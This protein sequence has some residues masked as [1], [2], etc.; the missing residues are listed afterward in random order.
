[1][2]GRVIRARSVD[3]TALH[4]E[5]DGPD[6]APPILFLH[7]VAGTMRS[8][9]LQVVELASRYR[10]IRFNARGYPPSDVPENPDLYSQM[11]AVEDAEAVLDELSIESAHIVGFSMGGFAAA[12]L[13]LKAPERMRSAMIV[14]AGYGSNPDEREQFQAEVAGVA[15]RFRED[16]PAAARAYADGPTRMQLKSKAPDRWAAFRDALLEHDPVGMSNTFAR[17]QGQRSS[18]ISH[19]DEFAA[20]RTPVMFVVGDEDDGC[21]ETNLALK[22]AM[23]S[24]ALIV[25]P[26]TG[27]TPNLEDPGRFTAI[28]AQ[29]ID[30]AE[31]GRWRSRVEGSTGRGL[32]GLGQELP[33]W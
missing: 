4:V 19:L 12:H 21:L 14:G 3:G 7:E 16:F 20:V 30:D 10:C 27:H 13:L 9:D 28:V 11:I 18:L 8:W 2:T 29:F 32:V 5:A 26:R 23:P 24:S 15:S 33:R 25:L 6:D 17:V 1:M 31:A 22:R